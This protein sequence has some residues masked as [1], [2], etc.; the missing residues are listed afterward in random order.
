MDDLFIVKTW[1]QHMHSCKFDDWPE[2]MKEW[3]PGDLSTTMK[4]MA[5]DSNH[6]IIRKL[7]HYEKKYFVNI[8]L[9]AFFKR[10][11]Y[12]AYC[13]TDLLWIQSNHSSLYR[14]WTFRTVYHKTQGI[15]FWKKK[16][17]A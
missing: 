14:L 10:K 15:V 17:H 2:M 11:I 7:R 13:E 8:F 12:S 9:N 1:K 5:K 3:E 4:K 16:K 6:P